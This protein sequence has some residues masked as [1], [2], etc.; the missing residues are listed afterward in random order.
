MK[1]GRIIALLALCIG[2]ALFTGCSKDNVA[3]E[4]S[5]TTKDD[6]TEY[7]VDGVGTFY[8]PEGFQ[9]ES[10][11]TEEGL[12]MHYAEMTKD[13]LY[14]RA[15][16]FGTDAYEAAGVPLPEDLDDYSTRDG[17]RQNLPEDAEFTRDKYDNLYVKYT[18]DGSINYQ[19]L[20]KGT[21]SYGAFMVICPEGEEDDETFALWASKVTLE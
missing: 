19:Y 4:S 18:Q 12:P 8:L 10:G 9:V 17:V 21:E 13:S 20:K 2:T 3:A 16:R 11:V 6:L 1:T 7:S 5:A 14:V 15:S